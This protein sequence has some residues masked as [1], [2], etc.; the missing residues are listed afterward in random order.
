MYV[1]VQFRINIF[2]ERTP[3]D[4]SLNLLRG[5]LSPHAAHHFLNCICDSRMEIPPSVT[6]NNSQ[7]VSVFVFTLYS[8]TILFLFASA[9]LPYYF[10]GVVER[11]EV[12]YSPARPPIC[13]H[14]HTC[15]NTQ[16]NTQACTSKQAHHFKVNKM[17]HKLIEL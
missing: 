8:C 16:R 5:E 2:Y 15:V 11:C 9:V 12:I 3:P 10:H 1:E 6:R 17:L 14:W 13:L 4:C 7:G